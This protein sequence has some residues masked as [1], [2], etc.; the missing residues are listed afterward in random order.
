MLIPGE[1]T[2]YASLADEKGR[3]LHKLEHDTNPGVSERYGDLVELGRKIKRGGAV[4]Q[5][6]KRSLVSEQFSLLEEIA[7][8][9]WSG[10]TKVDRYSLVFA[11]LSLAAWLGAMVLVPAR[12]S[13]EKRLD[14]VGIIFASALVLLVINAVVFFLGPRRAINTRV[15]PCLAAGL[16]PLNP[17]LEELEAILA[18]MRSAGYVYSTRVSPARITKEI[19]QVRSRGLRTL[20]R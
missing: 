4:S 6:L 9:C 8:K 17:S 3:D 2:E 12:I 15:L 19:Q 18:D 5:D 7:A 13:Q 11:A 1:K 10:E 20:G 14:A 16:E